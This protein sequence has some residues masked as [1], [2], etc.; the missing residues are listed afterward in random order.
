M[1]TVY[2]YP[3]LVGQIDIGVRRASIDGRALQLPLISQRERVVALHQVER[4]DWDEGILELEVGLP[5]AELADGPWAAV[6]CLAVLTEGAT[7]TRVVSRLERGRNDTHWRGEV[8]VLRSMHLARATL[9]VSVVG[10]YGGVDGRIIGSSDKPWFVDFLARTPLRQREIDIV[11]EDFRDGEQEWLRPFKEAPWLVETAGDMPT[12]LLNTSFE[13]VAELLGAP[14]GPLE[15]ATAGLIAAQIAGDAWTVMFHS[16]LADLECDEDGT[17]RLPGDWRESVLRAMLPDVFPGRSLA[18]AL[19]EA[20]NRRADGGGWAELQPRI[21]FAA[22]R[23]AL[24][25]KNLTAVIRAAAR[26]QEGAT[27]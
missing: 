12:V 25:P 5:R 26:V 10:S 11:E 22:A 16:A 18:D 7:N 1:S 14:R 3:T 13:G 20:H 24:V 19:L 27:R 8:S 15:K 2:P 9:D 23:R 4:N 17:P 21:Q 6:V